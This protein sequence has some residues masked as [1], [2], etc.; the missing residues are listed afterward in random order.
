MIDEDEPA[1]RF[2]NVPEGRP[3]PT[4]LQTSR[5]DFPSPVVNVKS[6][7]YRGHNHRVGS[8][9][10]TADPGMSLLLSVIYD[11]TLQLIY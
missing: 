5:S 10:S 3:L 8:L 11:S 1:S 7:L 9:Y 4:G 2:S 6:H